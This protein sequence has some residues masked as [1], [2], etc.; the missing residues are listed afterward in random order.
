ML[1]LPVAQ[2]NNV[3]RRTPWVSFAVIALNFLVLLVVTFGVDDETTWREISSRGNQAVHYVVE[4]PYLEAPASLT[5]HLDDEDVA[6]LEETRRTATLPPSDQLALEQEELRSLMVQFEEAWGRLSFVRWGYIPARGGASSMLTS[7]FMHAGWMHLLGNMLFL[8]LSG[9]FIEDRYGRPLFV[10]FYLAAG[11]LA[12][13]SHAFQD[14]ANTRPLVGAS[15]AIAGLMG[16][17]LIRL[18]TSRIRFL[19]W[20]LPI[21]LWTWRYSVLLPAFV[22]LP[23]WLAEQVWY[24]RSAE[25]QG[26][27]WWA[28]IGGFVF[29]A[30]VAFALRVAKVEERWIDAG[31][32]RQISIVQHPGLEKAVDLRTS[33]DVARARREI[34]R[35][36]AADPQNVDAWT[37]VYEIALAAG[38]AAEAGRTAQRLLDM[39]LRR[40]ERELAWQLIADACERVE[41]PSLPARFLISAGAFFEKE[42]DGRNACGL[43][44]RI[45]SGKPEDPSAFRAWFRQ[46]EILRASGDLA[47]ART[48]YEHARRHPACVDPWPQAIDRTLARMASGIDRG[49]QQQQ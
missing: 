43:Y 46:A 22:V 2:E 25:G 16:A 47:G 36:L 39:H 12:T 19:V 14:V 11:A 24:A 40:G 23:L 7:I 1:I 18:G 8:F 21:P 20:P 38:D 32:E 5:R 30:A 28:H 42:G 13:L 3:V 26:V 35:V 15:G 31:I 48:A 27:A 4:H 6:A 33:G 41:G 44:Q 17:F 9:P 45:T 29:G 49:L 34:Q 10:L 37:E